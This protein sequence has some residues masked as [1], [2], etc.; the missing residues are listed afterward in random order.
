MAAP[1]R[2]EVEAM[3]AESL[4]VFEDRIGQHMVTQ[5]NLTPTIEQARAGLAEVARV[6]QEKID[7]TETRVKELITQNNATFAEH[8]TAMEKIVSDLL[9]AGVDGTRLN[10]IA[11]KVDIA[12]DGTK[13]LSEKNEKMMEDLDKLAIEFKTQV[14]SVKIDAET[15]ITKVRD[16]ASSWADSFKGHL[17]ELMKASSAFGGKGGEMGS[18][19]DQDRKGPSVDRKEI[20]VWKLPIGV[21][22]IEFR[23]WADTVDTHFDAVLGFKFPEIVLDKVKRSEVPVDASN[24]KDIIAMVNVDLPPNKDMDKA[25]EER[26]KRGP[27]GFMG[28][29][30]ADPWVSEKQDVLS[31]WKF[32][33]KSRFLW[34]FLLNKLNV[35]LYSK[36]LGIDGRNGFELYRQVVR[37]VDEIPENAKFLMGAEIANLVH[38]FGDKVKDLKTLYG[39]RLMVARQAAAYKKTIGEAVDPEKLRELI[40]NAMDPSSKMTA[41]QMGVHRGDYDAMTKFID[42]RYRVTFGHVEYHS[43]KDDPMGIFAMGVRDPEPA[44]P[45]PTEQ[46]QWQQQEY[47]D[48]DHLGAFGKKG[49]KGKGKG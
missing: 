46:P 5:A 12:L 15:H 7:A 16:E 49:G 27:D 4:R 10:T 44:E 41:T 38:K 25:K 37:A 32:E 26:T 14:D 13:A 20:S 21:S 1:S 24:W 8:K 45:T 22:K 28:G 43:P 29:G 31:D 18:G 47:N 9:L 17:T 6:S 19:K 3:I 40:W 33:E 30:L 36:T 11:S 48:Q 35:E 42:E 2:A 23:H 34:N 39:F